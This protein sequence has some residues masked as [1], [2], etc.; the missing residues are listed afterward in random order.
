MA[1][2]LRGST[3]TL[4]G[5]SVFTMCTVAPAN[6]RSTSAS[7]LESPHSN[8]CWP[9]I[10]R[11]PGRVLGKALVSLCSKEFLQFF[12]GEAEHV[13]VEIQLLKLG[14]FLHEH[15]VVPVSEFGGLIVGEAIRFYLGRAQAFGDV[16][17]RFL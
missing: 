1:L 16:H 3:R 15:A 14:Q 6:K 11:S 9:R 2:L 7:L 13:E 10:H 17:G 4:Y 12:A 5:Q 8:R